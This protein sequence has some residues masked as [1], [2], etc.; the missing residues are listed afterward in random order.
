MSKFYLTTPIYYVNARPHIGHAYTTIMSD[1]LARFKK[2]C[3]DEVFFLTGT[4]EHGE[5][6]KK[7]AMA[8]GQEP[9]PFVDAVSQNFKDLWKSLNISYD[10]FIRTT[11]QVHID[12]VRQALTILYAKGDIY[13]TKYRGF[14]CM[15]CESF[16]TDSQVKEAGGCPD[17]KRSVEEIEEENYFFKLSKYEEWLKKYLRDNPGF[18]MPKI[19]HNEV[20]GFLEN[21]KLADLCISRPVKRVS[22]GITLP[23]DQEYVVYVWF[24]ALLNYITGIGAYSNEERFKKMWPADIHFMAKDILKQ[25]AVFW[26]IMLQALGIEQPRMVFAHGWW[27]MGDE[28]IS[29]SKG[30]AVSPLELIDSLKLGAAG[31]DALR[32]FL[33]REVPLG[34]DGNFS[35]DALV[36][37]VNSDLANDLGNLVYRTLTMTEKYFQGTVEAPAATQPKEFLAAFA[38]LH[39]YRGRMDSL[40]FIGALELIFNFIRVMNKYVEDTKPW[41]LS[42]EKKTEELAAFMYALLEG[43]RV[44]ALHLYPFIPASCER[45]YRQLGLASTFS[46]EQSRWGLYTRYT[47]KKEAPLFPRI[48]VA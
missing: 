25:H 31:V 14:Y 6:I 13:K 46:I 23:F 12:A 17:C 24:D 43:I 11:Q 20:V 45:I 15:P 16:W 47:I 42:K 33:L 9:G 39:E 40:E 18:V 5:K 30:N 36:I 27:K 41:N 32:Y 3:G 44:V 48:D 10:F 22:W 4:D 34:A 8:A 28:K 38:A 19:R 7:A 2:I 29:K 26:P 1:C 21:N 37:R 35:R